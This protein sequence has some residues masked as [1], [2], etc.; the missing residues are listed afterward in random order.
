MLR[1]LA[2]RGRGCS[3]DVLAVTPGKLIMRGSAEVFLHGEDR[4]EGLDQVTI[5]VVGQEVLMP[6][7]S[8]NVDQQWL[9]VGDHD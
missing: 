9:T 3:I 5:H 1:I 4:L 2:L 6:G 7:R 8:T